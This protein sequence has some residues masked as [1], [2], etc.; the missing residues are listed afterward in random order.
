MARSRMWFGSRD[1]MTWVKCPDVEMP[2]SKVGWTSRADYLN[3][4]AYVRHSTAAHKEYTLSWNY[5]KK[6]ELREILDYADRL[7]GDGPFY[8]VDPYTAD[9]NLLPQWFAS[10]FQGL[11]DGIILNGSTTRGESII[12]PQNT[13][14]YPTRSIRYPLT[15]GSNTV[16]CWVP[17]PPGYTAWVGAHGPNAVT[18]AGVTVK[19]DGQP[20]VLVPTL[21]VTDSTRVTD[22]FDG[23]TAGSGI[24]VSLAAPGIGIVNGHTNPFFVSGGDAPVNQ[25]G[26]SGPFIG[27]YNGVSM[28]RMGSTVN[29]ATAIRLSPNTKR[30]SAVQGDTIHA[31]IKVW[32]AS[33]GS[34]SVSAQIRSASDAPSSGTYTQLSLYNTPVVEIAAGDFHIF[35]FSGTITDATAASAVL[36]VVRWELGSPEIGDETFIEYAYISHDPLPSGQEVFSGASPGASWNGTPNA[37]TSTLNVGFVTLSGIMVQVLKTGTSPKPGGFIS[38]Q[39]HSGCSFAAQPDYVPYSAA[40]QINGDKGTGGLVAE[41]VETEGWVG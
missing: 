22:S 14:G 35:D 12:T 36:T 5:A 7:Y 27:T 23:G 24:E 17:I 21:G 15:E 30:I 6:E 32:N 9:S 34:R 11:D 16:R 31:R 33:S 39:G 8:W 3:G 2:S 37:S 20:E 10:P 28:G 25:Q 13:L 29:T 41:F 19:Q 4:G 18:D 40:L 1:R 38:G 26:T